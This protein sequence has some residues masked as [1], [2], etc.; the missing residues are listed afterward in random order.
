MEYRIFD[1]PDPDLPDK[2]VEVGVV[3]TTVLNKPFESIVVVDVVSGVVAH[4]FR[5]MNL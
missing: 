3:T 2:A 5:F 1:G 4:S